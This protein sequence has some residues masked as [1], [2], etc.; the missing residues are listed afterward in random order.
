M[1]LSNNNDHFINVY[2]NNDNN[3]CHKITLKD[4]MESMDDWNKLAMSSAK[5]IVY[6]CDDDVVLRSIALSIDSTSSNT[7]Q[8]S[9]IVN[10]INKKIKNKNDPQSIVQRMLK[11]IKKMNSIKHK[12]LQLYEFID[13]LKESVY[14]HV[15]FSLIKEYEAACKLSPK[16]KYLHYYIYFL[17]YAEY[18]H[19]KRYMGLEDDNTQKNFHKYY[20]K[21]IKLQINFIHNIIER[22]YQKE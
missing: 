14:T 21:N 6:K 16:T 17:H 7:S 8:K 10:L 4:K 12:R 11:I 5:E 9:S 3:E 22:K 2:D 15:S 13:L 18:Y 19:Y 1:K 20:L